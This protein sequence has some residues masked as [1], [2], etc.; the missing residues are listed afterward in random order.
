VVRHLSAYPVE[1]I[2][3]CCSILYPIPLSDFDEVIY[4]DEPFY[5][6][7]VPGVCTRVTRKLDS[8]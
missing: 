3:L 6:Y 8:V 7:S 4:L 2:V 1:S 5:D